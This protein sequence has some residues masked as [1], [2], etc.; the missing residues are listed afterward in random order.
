MDHSSQDTKRDDSHQNPQ[1]PSTSTEA[2]EPGMRPEVT[3]LS[4]PESHFN[5]NSEDILN[6]NL[7]SSYTDASQC[8]ESNA[9]SDEQASHADIPVTASNHVE[10]IQ[11][12][13]DMFLIDSL[14]ENTLGT[15]PSQPKE[16][17]KTFDM[18]D[19]LNLPLGPGSV[20]AHT[21]ET[22]KDA[23]SEDTEKIS[24]GVSEEV[25]NHTNSGGEND[26]SEAP[27][28]HTDEVEKPENSSPGEHFHISSSSEP[29]DSDLPD[30]VREVVEPDEVIAD[31][32]EASSSAD[33]D[34]KG[35][36]RKGFKRTALPSIATDELEE[37]IKHNTNEIPYDAD[38]HGFLFNQSETTTESRV[39]HDKTQKRSKTTKSPNVAKRQVRARNQAGLEQQS[40]EEMRAALKKAVRQG[41]D[42]EELKRMVDSIANEE[43]QS[44][45]SINRKSMSTNG[46][47]ITQKDSSLEDSSSSDSS[48][49]H[50]KLSDLYSASPIPV[51][52][53]QLEIIGHGI[54]ETSGELDS[55]PSQ[56]IK[57]EGTQASSGGEQSVSPTTNGNEEITPTEVHANPSSGRAQTLTRSELEALADRRG[58][59]FGELLEDAKRRGITLK[60]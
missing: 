1:H 5:G 7:P 58:L 47:N 44:D 23:I 51:D 42:P 2:N 6:Q 35:P 4:T 29:S 28:V 53:E 18:D 36:N 32:H 16:P 21:S 37:W 50:T 54:T 45:K 55:I 49:V 22:A 19:L 24:N 34:T 12:L 43:V 48:K 3:P 8:V 39:P 41:L 9:L 38:K 15:D 57:N 25:M 33:E 52:V 31:D 60:E 20:K 13:D 30:S 17:E 40:H 11:D 26:L 46:G 59:S 10:P 14:V 56:P 27:Q